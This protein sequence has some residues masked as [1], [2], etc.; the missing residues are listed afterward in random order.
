MTLEEIKSNPCA[1]DIAAEALAV[2]IVRE[3]SES[4]LR[5]LLKERQCIY[6]LSGT[7][8]EQDRA[9]LKVFNQYA[10]EIRAGVK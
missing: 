6:G 1:T 9:F 4:R 7:E 3:N 5:E 10:P 2:L 8:A